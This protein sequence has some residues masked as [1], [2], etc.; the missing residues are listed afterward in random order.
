MP[1]IQTLTPQFTFCVRET[2][3]SRHNLGSEV[4][5]QSRTIKRL[6]NI[7]GAHHLPL[8]PS[9]WIFMGS[10]W[11][12]GAQW[13]IPLRNSVSWTKHYSSCKPSVHVHN[14]S[15]F[16][17]PSLYIEVWYLPLLFWLDYHHDHLC[18][19][20]PAWNQGSSHW[21]DNLPVE[22]A[23]VLEEGSACRGSGSCLNQWEAK[24][25][26]GASEGP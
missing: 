12:D 10:P 19:H 4:W 15:G 11:V 23:L 1:W 5:Q 16:P 6:L 20:I 21:G 26:N 25:F 14:S 7:G 17:F 13:D 9:F 18:L 3:D 22:E 24:P 8:C 2:G